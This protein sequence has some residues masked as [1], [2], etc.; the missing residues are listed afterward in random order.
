MIQSS[1]TRAESSPAYSA[2]GYVRL[3]FPQFCRLK[4]LTRQ[5]F[6]DDDL[7]RELLES[8]VPALS[9]G[10]C[11][12]LDESTS[13]RISVGWAWFTVHH[14]LPQMLAPGGVSSNVMLTTS[15]GCDLGPT[16][17]DELLQAWLSTRVWE[18]IAE[19][20]DFD[21]AEVAYSIH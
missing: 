17:T 21:L 9:A 8:N 2:D 14:A 15:D 7:R 11:D 13:V 20:H 18:T 3:T 5:S 16:R 10:Y 4:F 6:D 19:V 1:K 12:W